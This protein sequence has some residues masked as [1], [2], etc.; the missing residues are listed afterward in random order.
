MEDKPKRK[1][2]RPSVF[3]MYSENPQ[4]AAAI[5]APNSIFTYKTARSAANQYYASAGLSIIL[6]AQPFEN[7]DVFVSDD[8]KEAYCYS[9]LEQLGRMSLQDGYSDDD[10]LFIAK[11][12]AK[13]K[14]ERIVPLKILSGILEVGAKRANGNNGSRFR[15][16]SLV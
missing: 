11:I 12:A 10:V 14:R 5:Y 3:E 2:G 4:K 8:A 13:A 1:R 9:I 16:C 6:E 15:K 7:S